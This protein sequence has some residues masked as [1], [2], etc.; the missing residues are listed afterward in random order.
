[1]RLLRDN[2]S[3]LVVLIAFL[4]AVAAF[5]MHKKGKSDIR[6]KEIEKRI[7]LVNTANSKMI[8]NKIYFGLEELKLI[9]RNPTVA[10]FIN[11]TSAST[12]KPLSSEPLRNVSKVTQRHSSFHTIL[13][14]N[15]KGKI[16]FSQNDDFSNEDL[17]HPQKP[18]IQQLARLFAPTL[19]HKER[20]FV[21][22]LDFF[23]GAQSEI[24]GLMG[25][26]YYDSSGTF[27]GCIIGE[28]PAEYLTAHLNASGLLPHLTAYIH[29]DTLAINHQAQVV[30]HPEKQSDML[31][32]LFPIQGKKDW[33]VSASIPKSEIHPPDEFRYAFL[34]ATIVFFLVLI[35]GL[36]VLTFYDRYKRTKGVNS[37][38]IILVQ[39]SWNQI[40]EYSPEIIKSFYKYLFDSSPEIRHMF[41][42][43]RHVQEAKMGAMVNMIVNSI[44]SMDEFRISISQL[45][46]GHAY[47]GVKSEHFQLVINAL[48]RSIEEQSREKFTASHKKS[49]T[50]VLQ[51]ISNMMME[52]MEKA[53]LVNS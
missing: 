5:V 33:A 47:M 6:L 13:I 34:R 46:K 37:S 28:F 9:G 15:E 31:H 36:L 53:R 29:S 50:K 11:Q 38:D 42:S 17:H 4:G 21:S 41:K 1:M 51:H 7:L 52:E 32:Y 16:I 18:F 35:A 44:D 43:E 19:Q 14:V 8:S 10:S 27:T 39:T 25:V 20:S 2:Y 49:W 23:N 26:L 30:K 3:I 24:S 12:I 40:S 48:I 22:T 45:A